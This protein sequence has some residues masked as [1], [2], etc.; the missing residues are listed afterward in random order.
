M[1][2]CRICRWLYPLDDVMLMF[3]SI[4]CVC[5]RCYRRE[6]VTDKP[7]P[8]HLQRELSQVIAEATA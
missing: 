6:T 3:G 7:M 8:K 2:E 5:V 4:R 1:Y